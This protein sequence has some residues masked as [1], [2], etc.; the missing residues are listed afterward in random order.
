MHVLK[1][2]CSH[3]VFTS[4]EAIKNTLIG[5]LAF[6]NPHRRRAYHSSSLLSVHTLPG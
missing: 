5:R 6:L 2:S 4:F 1:S 3:I